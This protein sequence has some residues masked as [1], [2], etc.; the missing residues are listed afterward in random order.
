MDH[1]DSSCPQKRGKVLASDEA[2]DGCCACE[3]AGARPVAEESVDD[4]IGQ[5]TS[6]EGV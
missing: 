3:V 2:G 5:S 4:A 1:V 6:M